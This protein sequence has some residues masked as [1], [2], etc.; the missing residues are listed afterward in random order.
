MIFEDGIVDHDRYIKEVLPA[1]LKFDNDMLGTDWIFQ[2]DGEKPY[3]HA[4]LG[5]WCAKHLS[6]PI[7][8]EHWSPNGP[9]LNP[10]DYN[11]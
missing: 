9:D 4:E 6:C 10:L 8:T 1:A 5:E 3:I 2:H 11:I 7:D